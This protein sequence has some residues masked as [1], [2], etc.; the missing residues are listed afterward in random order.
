MRRLNLG[1]A[2]RPRQVFLSFLCAISL[3]LGC[4]GDPSNPDGEVD[5][6]SS[7]GGNIWNIFDAGSGGSDQPD[8]PDDVTSD[9][10]VDA[11]AGSVPIQTG[12][13][14]AE[15]VSPPTGALEGGYRARVDGDGFSPESRVFFG[16]N[17]A[18]QLIFITGRSMTCRVPPGS[19][20]G[21]TT[22]RVEDPQGIGQLEGAFTY[23][24]QSR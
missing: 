1:S 15:A 10:G 23:F 6:S 12:P 19:A 24:H 13:V 20:P 11:D 2:S 5:G 17:E 16:E 4:T 3:S 18:D 14:V 22:V 21:P 9:G 7:D 8:P